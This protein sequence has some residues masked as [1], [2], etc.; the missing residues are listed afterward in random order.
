MH[1]LATYI[2]HLLKYTVIRFNNLLVS[3]LLVE[4]NILPQTLCS[5]FN[6]PLL[7][8]SEQNRIN[9]NLPVLLVIYEFRF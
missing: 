1:L 5:C 7:S 4:A 9:F 6:F 3:P 8:S 2:S